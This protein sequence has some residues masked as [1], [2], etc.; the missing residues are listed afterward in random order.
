M[1]EKKFPVTVPWYRGLGNDGRQRQSS[2]TTMAQ[3]L[4]N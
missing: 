2:G 1:E 4:R 3:G